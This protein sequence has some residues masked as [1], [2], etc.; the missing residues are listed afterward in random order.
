MRFGVIG[1]TGV[2]DASELADLREE[3][4]HT[5]YG[6]AK[7]SLGRLGSQEVVFMARHGAGHGIPPHRINYRA[8]IWALRELDVRLVV[9]TASVG[10]LRRDLDVGTLVLVDQFLDF[11]KGRVSTFYDGGA[12]GVVHT[13]VTSPYCPTLREALAASGSALGYETHRGGTYAVTEGPRFETAA[14]IH[15]LRLLGAD[16]VGMTGCPEVAL[17]RELGLCYATIALVTNLAAGIAPQPLSH[18]EVVAAMGSNVQRVRQVIYG[19]FARLTPET[20]CP[21]CAR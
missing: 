12:E 13:D 5:P 6:Q 14:E 8:N 2:Y 15:M 21:G 4:V 9:A 3:E 1:G 20:A 17:A 11:T 18:E 7:A 19:A 16:L 10:S